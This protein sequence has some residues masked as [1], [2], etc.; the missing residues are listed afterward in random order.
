MRTTIRFEEILEIIDAI[1]NWSK[2]CSFKDELKSRL[3]YAQNLPDN[4][5]TK[6]Q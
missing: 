5:D 2:Q 4:I 6:I 3:E 1:P